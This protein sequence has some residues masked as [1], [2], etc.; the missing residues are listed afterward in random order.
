M[1]CPAD[2]FQHGPPTVLFD[3]PQPGYWQRLSQWHR[4]A[5]DRIVSGGDFRGGGFRWDRSVK[6]LG[7]GWDPECKVPEA[8][9]H[10][11]GDGRPLDRPLGLR[12]D[13]DGAFFGDISESSYSTEEV[14]FEIA[15]PAVASRVRGF[16][17]AGGAK[18][19]LAGGELI[20]VNITPANVE[21]GT[22]T[23]LAFHRGAGFNGSTISATTAK[24]V[25]V[26][27]GAYFA[28]PTAG[29]NVTL[30]QSYY[31]LGS[32]AIY[33]TG[34]AHFTTTKQNHNKPA[35][36][37]SVCRPE[38]TAIAQGF[39]Y[40]DIHCTSGNVLQWTTAP[41]ATL[42]LVTLNDGAAVIRST[43]AAVVNDAASVYIHDAPVASTNV[44]ITRP[45]ALWVQ[46]G[47]VKFGGS[48][49]IAGLTAG[50]V[51][52]AGTSGILSGEAGLYWDATNDRLGVNT[53]GAPASTVDLRG[54]GTSD[55]VR[56]QNTN[57][58]GLSS[59]GYFNSSGT[60]VAA[61]GYANASYAD[62]DRAGR[63]FQF[64]GA[65]INYTVTDDVT[66]FIFVD[67]TNARVGINAGTAPTHAL[68]VRGSVGGAVPL[69]NIRNTSNAGESGLRCEDN[70]GV[71][72]VSFG[73]ENASSGGSLASHCFI[74]RDGNARFAFRR[75]GVANDGFWNTDGSFEWGASNALKVGS[76]G[77]I[78]FFGTAVQTQ[79]TV[80]G[81]RGGNAALASLLTQLAGYGLIVDSST[82]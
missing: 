78:G 63:A 58:A 70:A 59:V 45:W 33:V 46:A 69:I 82:A 29:T 57:A 21:Y 20:D 79:K 23:L 3:K 2:G 55:V 80:T 73:Y 24:T 15:P 76:A 26:A 19:A 4:E 42:R 62:T 13:T 25:S 49:T 75:A 22:G 11:Q 77:Q 74:I 1:T 44:T 60:V 51:V 68:D 30:D 43:A 27:V 28:A 16:R 72:K 36:P 47:A 10:I 53:A 50:H 39:E 35:A 48:L 61:T 12:V 40:R 52:Y 41:P 8:K 31:H 18:T 66:H 14:F 56:V 54:G 32:H 71:F 6:R 5:T 81:S 17:Y 38:M 37:I 7:I 34:G 65:G 9:V 64:I 67:Q